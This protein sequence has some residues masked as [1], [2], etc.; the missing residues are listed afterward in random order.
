MQTAANGT[1]ETAAAAR[2]KGSS[3]V[4]LASGISGPSGVVTLRTDPAQRIARTYH[5]T[6]QL[7]QVK[8]ILP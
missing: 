2:D 5:I 8:Y 6:S 3:S 7:L 1:L 4:D